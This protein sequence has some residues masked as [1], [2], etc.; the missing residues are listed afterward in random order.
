MRTHYFKIVTV[1]LLLFVTSC[2][3]ERTVQLTII[4]TSDVHGAIFPYDFSENKPMNTSL[5]NVYS[6]VETARNTKGNVI[7]LDNGDNLQGQPSVYYYNFL[8]TDGNHILSDVMNF[9]RYDAASVGNHDI[10]AG[11]AVYDKITKE[12]QFPLL[13]ANAIDTQTGNPYFIP[14]T[15]IERENVKVAVLGMTNP[16]IPS[17][18]P[19][20]LWE[21]MTF[22]DVGESAREWVKYIQQK[23]KPH[24]MIGLFHVG[25]GDGNDE[26]EDPGLYIAQNIPGFDIMLLGH[27]H[28]RK[29][30]K[31]ANTLGDSVLI[32]NP[33]NAARFIAEA[34]ITL[35]MKGRKVISKAISGKLVSME[36]YPA[37][38]TF[39]QAF[40]GAF[41]AVKS[42]VM[43]PI[44]EL[45]KTISS[46]DAYFGPSAFIDLIHGIQLSVAE[47][48]ISFTAPLS[49]ES[50]IKAGTVRV[51]DM[52]KLYRYENML[53]TMTLSG[54]EIKNYL[55]YSYGAWIN[56][57]T[58]PN[59][60]LLLFGSDAE[61]GKRGSFVV[62]PYNFDSSAGILY[63]VDATKPAGSKIRIMSMADKTP[64]D[65]TQT[66]RVAINSYRGNGGGGHLEKG[67]GISPDEFSARIVK[68]TDVDLRYYLMKWFEQQEV[69]NPAPLNQW[70]IVPDEWVLK[71]AKRDYEALFPNSLQH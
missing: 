35:N 8:K 68:S 54:K 2:T 46:R 43:K 40:S 48:D 24:I 14:Y 26:G 10:E 56:E 65:E 70:K 50:E 15:I 29:A 4:E 55:E 28:T 49:F 51:L 18:L 34:D 19:K 53:Y 3:S 71:A 5:A 6:Y 33:A 9:M 30:M 31:V 32:L 37:D 1:L 17:W 45:A 59:D 62:P 64:F 60:H 61:S 42:F 7:L 25:F 21:G 38:T 69:V 52:F 23:E 11:H 44:G 47:A 27:D 63:E 39:M 67:A 36:D 58:S 66:Y 16:R 22:E 41:D 57:M 13:A 12:Y 20:N